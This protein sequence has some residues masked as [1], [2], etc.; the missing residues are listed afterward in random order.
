MFSQSHVVSDVIEEVFHL[1]NSRRHSPDP[2]WRLPTLKA[3]GKRGAPQDMLGTSFRIEVAA[4]GRAQ[5]PPDL[6]AS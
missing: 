5:R 6:T 3:R 1:K 2:R 4:V